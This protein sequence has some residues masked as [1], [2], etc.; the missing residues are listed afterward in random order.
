[1]GGRR[2]GQLFKVSIRCQMEVE[3]A[4]WWEKNAERENTYIGKDE[5]N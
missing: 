3:K 1:M 4:G 2:G 5:K